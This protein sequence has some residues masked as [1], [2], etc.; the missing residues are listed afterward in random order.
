MRIDKITTIN[1][2]WI[3]TYLSLLSEQ[4]TAKLHLHGG[5]IVTTIP[6]NHQQ[7][8]TQVLRGRMK[9]RQASSTARLTR[10]C[11]ARTTRRRAVPADQ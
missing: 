1:Y 3:R 5:R 9:Y 10:W 2:A 7:V 8:R 11:P 4:R 6:P